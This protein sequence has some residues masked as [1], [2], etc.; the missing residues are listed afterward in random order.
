VRG[1]LTKAFEQIGNAVP[2][3]LAKPILATALGVWPTTG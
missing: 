2:P 3:G 1:G